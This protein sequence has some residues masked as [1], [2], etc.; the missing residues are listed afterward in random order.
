MNAVP[1]IR[2]LGIDKWFG[3]TCAVAGADVTVPVGSI[4]ALLGPSGSGKSTLL[5]IIAGFEVPDA[6]MV[7]IDGGRV[8]G[9]GTWVEPELR[10]VG[11]V[12]QDGALFPHLTVE[13]NVAF[14]EPAPGRVTECLELVGLAHRARSYPHE[15]SGGERQRIALA[16]AL[17]PDPAVVLLDEPFAALDAGLRAALREDVAAIL[18]EAGATALLVTHDQQEALSLADEVVLMDAGRIVQTGTPEEVYARPANRWVAGFL[19]AAEVFPGTA[20][21]GYVE[22]EFGRL[23]SDDPCAQGPVEV[24]IRPEVLSL[25]PLA[26]DADAAGASVSGEVLNRSFFGHDQ[27]V[28][29]ELRSGRRVRSRV[30]GVTRWQT[31][32]LVGIRVDGPVH[33][34][35]SSDRV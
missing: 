35:P 23:L 8:A 22:T 12:F 32:D 17:A 10:R 14:G 2:A 33:V 11:M 30:H 29:L 15:L 4:V 25:V 27:L 19:G 3:R 28:T 21:H 20:S 26:A 6:G 31:G 16:R 34:L 24:M 18:R 13:R 1:A 9:E 5:R 7:E